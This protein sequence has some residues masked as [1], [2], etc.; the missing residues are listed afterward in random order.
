MYR[1]LEE[2]E[3]VKDATRKVRDDENRWRDQSAG[4]FGNIEFGLKG[5]SRCPFA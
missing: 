5:A 4:L 3:A 2:I 1:T